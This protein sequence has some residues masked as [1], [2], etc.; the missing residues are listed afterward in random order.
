MMP[1]R[2][3]LLYSPILSPSITSFWIQR[4]LPPS[5]EVLSESGRLR[6]EPNIFFY[7]IGFYT[8]GDIAPLVTPNPY[9]VHIAYR[10]A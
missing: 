5:D 9:D 7:N 4:L 6:V 3:I 2:V 10:N 1:Q 8:V